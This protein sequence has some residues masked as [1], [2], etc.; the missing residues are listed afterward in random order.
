MHALIREVLQNDFYQDRAVQSRR[1]AVEAAVAEGRLPA[2][3]AAQQL[4]ALAHR[5]E[6]Q[7]S[8]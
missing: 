5:G 2:L 3:A 8:R 1:S 4:L 7:A 6:D